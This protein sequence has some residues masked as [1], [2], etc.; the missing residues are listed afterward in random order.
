MTGF[1]LRGQCQ[2]RVSALILS[3]LGFLALEVK[4]SRV[5]NVC[6]C[7][8]IVYPQRKL[9]DASARQGLRRE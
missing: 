1:I 4:P 9:K 7:N 8:D 3:G 6:L 2:A 5:L